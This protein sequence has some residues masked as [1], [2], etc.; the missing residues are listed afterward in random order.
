MEVQS[1]D[2]SD[3]FAAYLKAVAD[4]RLAQGAGSCQTSERK[5]CDR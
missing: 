2:V 5:G 1:T 3:A 4:E